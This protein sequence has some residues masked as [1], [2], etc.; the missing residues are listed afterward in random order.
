MAGRRRLRKEEV[1]TIKVLAEKGESARG[2]A[3]RMEVDES[4]VRYHV[5]R[6][7]EGATDGRRDRQ[8]FKAAGWSGVIAG[9][10]EPR[11]VKGHRPPNVRELHELLVAEH[12]YAGSYQSVVRF[13]RSRYPR[14]RI[15][16][17]RRVETPP[18][19]QAQT[20]WGVYPQVRIGHTTEP[21]Y[22]F[23][24]T[25]S[26]SRFPAVVWSRR[27]DQMSWLWCHNR[28]FE[29]L[30]GIP[31]V[32]RV[33]NEK[34]AV[35]SGAGAWGEINATY[36]AY[37]RVVRFHIDACA[38]RAPHE[39]G[40]VE[41]KVKLSRLICGVA[42]TAFESDE[43]LQADTD[44]R[45][46]RWIEQA[47][48]PVTG[49]T[50]RESWEEESPFLQ[51]LPTLPEPFDVA[52]TRRVRPDGLIA[53]EG[54]SYAVPFAYVGLNVEVRGGAGRVQILADGQVLREYPRATEG[55]LLIDP[56]CYDGPSTDRVKAP[57]PLGRMGR[58]L[59]EIYEMTVEERPLDLYAALAE[60]SR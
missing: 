38:P 5:K 44:E 47:L 21:R 20:D 19:A 10:Y 8:P 23:V 13:V 36:L 42:G 43:H 53:F 32:N 7:D 56:S 4:T 35:A 55:R 24:M 45:V 31:A 17:Y 50:V 2:I 22:A 26:H 1:V 49:R 52:V 14:P 40:K 57:P 9:W 58:R 39:K 6:A 37:A 51:P 41:A 28:A 18:G 25:L 34:T 46:N 29:R 59:Q 3:R 30:G 60:A 33:D 15:R 54:R 11:M 27:K 48:C 16:T 12:G